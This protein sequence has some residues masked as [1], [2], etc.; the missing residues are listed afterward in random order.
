[1]IRFLVAGAISFLFFHNAVAQNIITC[2]FNL[3]YDNKGDSRNL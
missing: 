3:R 2:S 1:M